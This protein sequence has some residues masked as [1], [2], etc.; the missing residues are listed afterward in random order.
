[1]TLIYA[2]RGAS[3]DA[4]ENT[5]SSFN[6]A[7][8]LNADGIETDVQLTKDQAVVVIHD[9][10][11][12]RT[13]AVRGKVKDYS[14]QELLTLSNGEWFDPTFRDDKILSL[15][16]LLNWW[17]TT[18]LYLNIELKSHRYNDQG[19]V[20]ETVKQLKQVKHPEKLTLSSFNAMYLK[21]VKDLNPAL[22]TGYLT[23]KQLSERV[24]RKH[25]DYIDGIHLHYKAYTLDYLKKVHALGLYLHLYTVNDDVLFNDYLQSG[26]DGM[27]TD[28]PTLRLSPSIDD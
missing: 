25:L 21:Q 12:D 2:H 1:V 18:P 23:K 8:A 22:T 27:I 17:K 26:V 28:D 24:L 3:K 19:I 5:L 7:W 4:P 15:K 10:T 14:L 11:V 9:P 13:T 6:K 16:D 20:K